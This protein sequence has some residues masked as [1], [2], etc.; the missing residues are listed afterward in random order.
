ME[1]NNESRKAEIKVFK[2]RFIIYRK[3]KNEEK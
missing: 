1:N 3:I 2:K